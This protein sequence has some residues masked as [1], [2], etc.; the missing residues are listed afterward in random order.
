M[1]SL[2]GIHFM[3]IMQR[4]HKKNIWW[5]TVNFQTCNENKENLVAAKK[6]VISGLPEKIQKFKFY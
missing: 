3:Y 4:T 1:V 5:Y 6:K 2:K